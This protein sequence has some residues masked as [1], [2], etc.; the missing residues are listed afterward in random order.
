MGY[1]V[2]WGSLLPALVLTFTATAGLAA[3][4]PAAAVAAEA[5]PFAEAVN[6]S[7]TAAEAVLAQSGTEHCLR[8]KLTNALLGLSSSCEAQGQRSELCAF[9]DRVIV[10]TGWTVGF[11]ETTARQLLQLAASDLSSLSGGTTGS[12]PRP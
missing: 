2:P 9:A 11:M 5:K 6:S 7:R 1:L 8:G 3:T 10:T 12:G 4:T